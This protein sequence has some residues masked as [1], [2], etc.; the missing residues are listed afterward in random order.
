MS[1]LSNLPPPGGL[2]QQEASKS[3]WDDGGWENDIAENDD[4]TLDEFD[5]QPALDRGQTSAVSN[6]TFGTVTKSKADQKK[7]VRPT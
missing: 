5:K 1:S 4:W 7:G 6:V 2:K 3:A